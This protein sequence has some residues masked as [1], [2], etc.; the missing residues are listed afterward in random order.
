MKEYNVIL[1][2]NLGHKYKLAHHRIVLKDPNIVI[3]KR[4]YPLSPIKQEALKQQVVKLLKEGIIEELV[5][6]Y[7]NPVLLVSKKNGE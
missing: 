6:V 1:K 5:S 2:K 7:N 3:N 4:N